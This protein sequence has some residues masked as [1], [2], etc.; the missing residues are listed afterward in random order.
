[1]PVWRKDETFPE[2]LVR[3]GQWDS[4]QEKLDLFELIAAVVLD[5]TVPSEEIRTRLF[6][7]FSRE[8][9]EEHV[10]DLNDWIVEHEDDEDD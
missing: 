9:I 8:T 4:W 2:F 1:M 3:T 10:N 7:R 5:E 6:E